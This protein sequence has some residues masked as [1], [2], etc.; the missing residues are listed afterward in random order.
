MIRTWAKFN[1][2]TVALVA[3]D[4]GVSGTKSVA[5]R[6]GLGA[7]LDALHNGELD[8]LIVRDLDRLAREVTVQEALLAD[9]WRRPQTHVFTVHGEVL[10]DDPDDP[11]RTA[12]RQMVGVFAGLERRM[13]VKRMRDGRKA[14]AARGG[15]SVGPAPYGWT[16]KNGKLTRHPQEQ[17]ALKRMMQLHAEGYTTREIAAFLA[18]R[19]DL[20]PTKRGGAWTSPVVSRIIARTQHRPVAAA[21]ET[22]A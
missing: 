22:A 12:M 13:I 11:M 3:Q 8:G 9:V 15:H 20:Y 5:E 2:H 7:I 17:A 10:R 21:Q 4:A 1:G 16:A 6:P 19:P 18:E 14:K